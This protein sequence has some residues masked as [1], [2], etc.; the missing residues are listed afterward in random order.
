[1]RDVR[2]V[3]VMLRFHVMIRR[4]GAR[5]AAA[6]TAV[7]LATSLVVALPGSGDRSAEAAPAD[8]I[9]IVIEGTGNGHGRGM[10][11]WGAYGYAVDHGWS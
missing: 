11:Q 3:T 7:A 6:L 9:A 10:S 4:S 8:I 5:V 1:M 2:F